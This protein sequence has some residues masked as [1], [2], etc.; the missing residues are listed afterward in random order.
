MDKKE[1][2]VWTDNFSI[3]D[4]KIDKEHRKLFDIIND[5][6]EFIEFNK[7]REEFA[8]ILSKMTDYSLFH[9]KKEEN[10]MSKFSYPELTKH[11]NYHRDYIYKVS[12]FNF[13]LLSADPPNPSDIIDYLEKWW[14]NHIL[15]IDK[16]YEAYKEKIKSN[17]T[18]EEC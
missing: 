5:L 14:R 17:V 9:F 12:M 3:G 7:D 2:I 11:H 10:F 1:K 8:K 4:S 13:E 6:I 18:Y 16:D 15:T